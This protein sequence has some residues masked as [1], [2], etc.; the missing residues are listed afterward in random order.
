MAKMPYKVQLV[1]AKFVQKRQSIHVKNVILF[2]VQ[3]FAK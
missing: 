2:I 3:E 1:Y